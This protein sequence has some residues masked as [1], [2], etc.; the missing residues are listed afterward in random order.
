V[1]IVWKGKNGKSVVLKDQLTLQ[2]AEV[3]D[4]A[5]MSNKTL[6]DFFEK[7]IAD[8]KEKGVLLSLHLKATMMKVSDPIIFGSA[9]KVYFK[10]VFD[11]HKE[12][13]DETWHQCKQRTW[14]C[15]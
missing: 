2:A 11:K 15:V 14:Q 1:K 13:F 12:L 8:A 5:V 7:E 9:V 3:I 4:G 6:T 10:K